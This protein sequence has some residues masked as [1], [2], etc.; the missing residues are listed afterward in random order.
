MAP[1]GGMRQGIG[2]GAAGGS[3]SGQ[4]GRAGRSRG[5]EWPAR[6][7]PTKLSIRRRAWK[8]PLGNALV[9][10]ECIECKHAWIFIAFFCLRP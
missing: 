1:A 4:G 9:R 10:T 6:A 3:M 2:K 5:G 7:R 8:I